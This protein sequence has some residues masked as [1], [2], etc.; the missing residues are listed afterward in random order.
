M[1]VAR[2]VGCDEFGKIAIAHLLAHVVEKERAAEV[3]G[4]G[5]IAEGAV[6]VD[7]RVHV[8][9]RFEVVDAELPPPR[10]A[11]GIVVLEEDAFAIGG[12]RSSSQGSKAWSLPTR[13]YHH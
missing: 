3:H 12:E 6:I 9:G 8:A 10:D 11:G 2:G 5:V 13:L 4:V 7:G 1:G